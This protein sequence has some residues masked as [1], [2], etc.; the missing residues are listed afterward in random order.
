M[1]FLRS[2]ESERI[3][4]CEIFAIQVDFECFGPVGVVISYQWI[5]VVEVLVFVFVLM[6]VIYPAKLASLFK[7]SSPLA[8]TL[9]VTITVTTQ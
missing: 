2:G 3:Y 7:P 6:L 9:S 1:I 8:S 5:V 4:G